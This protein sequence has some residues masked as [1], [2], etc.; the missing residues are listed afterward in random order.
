MAF[1]AQQLATKRISKRASELVTNSRRTENQSTFK[2]ACNKWASWCH[3]HEANPFRCP[4]NFV[5]DFS[6]NLF[7]SGYSYR[8]I[9]THRSEISV[10]HGN[11]FSFNTESHPLVRRVLLAQRENKIQKL[12]S[13][14]W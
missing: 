9:G 13:N 2:P 4:V 11:D 8:L 7:Q 1:F 14:I 3:Q 10:F 12:D 5:L 6:V